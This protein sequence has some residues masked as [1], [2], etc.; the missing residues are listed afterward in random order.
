MPAPVAAA[1]R[2][3]AQGSAP[4]VLR[5]SPEEVVERTIQIP[6]GASDVIEP[7]L[8]N[9]MNRIVPWP[10]EET[11]FGYTVPENGPG[12]PDQID[13]QVAATTRAVLEAAL[14][15]VRALGA[16]P[17][18]VDYAAPRGAAGRHGAAFAR[19]PIPGLEWR[20]A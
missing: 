12:S 10:Q 4:I 16:R 2:A 18:L 1:F 7:V 11:R 6:K 20:T 5:L 8:R 19:R 3:A 13:V 9:Q 15:E 14:A 17:G